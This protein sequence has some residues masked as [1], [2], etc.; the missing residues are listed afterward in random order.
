MEDLVQALE[1]LLGRPISKAALRRCAR[2]GR[3]SRRLNVRINRALRL[4]YNG[5]ID[6]R[7][8]IAP[9]MAKNIARQ[10]LRMLG[11]PF[12]YVFRVATINDLKYLIRA[13]CIAFYVDREE[14]RVMRPSRRRRKQKPWRQ[15]W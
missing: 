8:P 3:Q 9:E 1:L 4:L 14:R 11:C 5:D 6:V 15:R 2:R 7:Q 12:K 10:A 13:N